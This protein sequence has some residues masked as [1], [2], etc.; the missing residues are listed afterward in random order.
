MA[1]NN[2]K[3]DL[4]ED[5]W[6]VL[7]L[8]PHASVRDIN[9]AFETLRMSYLPIKRDR[10]IPI[11][12]EATEHLQKLDR[13]FRMALDSKGQRGTLS[14]PPV[15]AAIPKINASAK[16][17]TLT[18][19]QLLKR[20]KAQDFNAA[21]ILGVR[22]ENGDG[23][24]D[25]CIEAARW[26]KVAAEHGHAEAKYRLGL[27]Y[28]SGI[29]VFRDLEVAQT[30]IKSAAK[31]GLAPAVQ[32]QF[33]IANLIKK[34]AQL[35]EFHFASGVRSETGEGLVSCDYSEAARLY[36]LA[37]ERGHTKAQ[38]NLSLL[39]REGLGVNK[40]EAEADKWLAR[41]M[42]QTL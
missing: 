6:D 41:S 34:E 42:A 38:H 39:Y 15:E 27:L 8:S 24:E 2:R 1:N 7:I 3:P 12:K 40:N 25:H 30:W 16:T 5:W 10:S 35:S 11:S 20:V 18:I 23:V 26:Y 19:N 14:K 29:G 37:A 33:V 28:K 36:R 22:Y 9:Q 32:E 21:Y 13:A 31:D 4:T 17:N